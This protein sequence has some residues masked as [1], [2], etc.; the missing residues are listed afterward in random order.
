MVSKSN[1]AKHR[2]VCGKKKPPKT[3]KVINRESYTR[4]KDII[5]N[6]RFEQRL[7]DRFR[8]LEG[9]K[10]ISSGLR[11]KL[12]G[13]EEQLALLKQASSVKTQL[14]EERENRIKA[15]KQKLKEQ[16]VKQVVQIKDLKTAADD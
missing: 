14:E 6:K 12:A 1:M 7:Y 11:K 8:R 3:R 4:H 13:V 5:H 10:A 9:E 16:I 15:E 2:K